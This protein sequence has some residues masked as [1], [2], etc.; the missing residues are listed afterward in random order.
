MTAAPATSPASGWHYFVVMIDHGRKG[1]EAVVDPELTRRN[2][3]ER[4]QS[5]EYDPDRIIFIHEVC[6][7]AATDI[8]GD[9]FDEVIHPTAE[10][11]TGQDAIDWQRDHAWNQRKHERV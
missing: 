9:I 7:G 1:R 4:V 8:T 3:V 11:L 5:R 6:D 10:R 2:I